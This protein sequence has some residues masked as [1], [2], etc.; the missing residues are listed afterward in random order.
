[1]NQ[2]LQQSGNCDYFLQKN[3]QELKLYN[4]S[5]QNELQNY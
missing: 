3:I 4:Q 1:M 2:N 5:L